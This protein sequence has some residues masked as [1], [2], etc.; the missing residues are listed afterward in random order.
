MQ[1]ECYVQYKCKYLSTV[2]MKLQKIG[3]DEGDRCQVQL[4][5]HLWS[6]YING[7]QFEQAIMFFSCKTGVTQKFLTKF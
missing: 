2:T 1:L 6:S 7:F 5:I 3:S 4:V